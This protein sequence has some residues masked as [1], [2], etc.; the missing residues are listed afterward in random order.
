MYKRTAYLNQ[1]LQFKDTEWIKVITGVRRSGK[2]YLLLLYKEMLLESGISEEQIIYLNFES[3]K[4]LNL[5]TAETLFDYLEEQ[6]HSNKKMYF[7]FDEIQHVANWP[8]LVAGLRVDFDCDITITGSNANMLAGDIASAIAGRYIQITMYPLSFKEFWEFKE[9]PQDPRQLRQL[10]QEYAMYGG[11]PALHN[12]DEE[13][14]DLVLEGIY[15]TVLL[16]DVVARGQIREV[17]SLRR[18]VEFL[19][20]N[21]G[22]PINR[23]KIVNTLQSSGIKIT[24]ATVASYLELLESAFIFYAAKQY[25]LRG[26]KLLSRTDKYYIVD[27]GLRG[28]ILG[29]KLENRG[30]MLEN[31][32]YIELLRRGYNVAVGKYD[33]KEVDF[34]ATKKDETL[35]L[36]V[37]L[38]LPETSTRETDNLLAIKDNYRKIVIT[39]QLED[40]V[41]I[42]GIPIINVVDWLLE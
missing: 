24:N 4:T 23:S 39:Q 42:D 10:Y 7:M 35:Y 32:V 15:D 18:V 21:I 19:A 29:K 36:Q 11:F 8:S 33:D 2:S 13:R 38:T 20:S 22:Q 5:R 27:T 17:D 3:N 16:N 25:D 30:S 6:V 37:A 41:E 9:Q 1:L 14:K 34:V 31:I 12:L 26:K 40:Q 28:V